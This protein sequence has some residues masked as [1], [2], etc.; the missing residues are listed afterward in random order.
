MTYQTDE[1]L[2][3]EIQEGN[4]LAFETIVKRYQS[5]LWHFVRRITP[6]E[7]VAE[8]VVQDAL[9][10][11]YRTIDRVDATRKVSSY[12]YVIA[13][14]A[15]VSRIRQEK[16]V[17]R[18]NDLEIPVDDETVFDGFSR[19]ENKEKVARTLRQLPTSY[20]R[21]IKMFYFDELSYEEISRTLKVPVNTVRTNIRRATLH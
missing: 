11:F 16:K 17:V 15:A 13:R 1:Q 20:R 2:V 9:L 5:R 12:L 19:V 4:I 14:N 3:R 6:R 21:V 8:E 18:L 7:G 10:H